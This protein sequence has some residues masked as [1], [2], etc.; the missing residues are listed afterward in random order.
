MQLPGTVLPACS[1]CFLP[2]TQSFYIIRAGR[3]CTFFLHSGCGRSAICRIGFQ[4]I[5]LDNCL[6]GC[7]S[8][9]FANIGVVSHVIR[10]NCL[11]FIR[12]F[13]CIESSFAYSCFSG[14]WVCLFCSVCF[15]L[16]IILNQHHFNLS[17]CKT[18]D[19]NS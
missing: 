11:L 16:F 17:G 6:F 12:R 4:R 13:C 7:G 1:G 2:F 8:C 10:S 14:G 5:A 3:S 9:R 15:H 19:E 18:A